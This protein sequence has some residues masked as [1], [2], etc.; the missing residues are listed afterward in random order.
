[1]GRWVDQHWANGLWVGGCQ[2]D[3]SKLAQAFVKVIKCICQSY[4]MYFL[5]GWMGLW[6]EEQVWG[7]RGRLPTSSPLEETNWEP[8]SLTFHLL[9]DP[10]QSKVEVFF[11]SFNFMILSMAFNIPILNITTLR[12]A[13]VNVDCPWFL[14]TNLK[15]NIF[16]SVFSP[17]ICWDFWLIRKLW[18]GAVCDHRCNKSRWV[19]KLCSK[20]CTK[21][22]G[23]SD[24]SP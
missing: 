8:C 11:I 2:H 19:L 14:I 18:D 7:L 9:A 15:L 1:M 22:W 23:F 17:Q 20:T 4:H 24:A 12:L 3:L 21:L 16:V 5:G 10:K 6:A 13:R